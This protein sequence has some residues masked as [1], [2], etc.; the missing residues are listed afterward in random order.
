MSLWFANLACNDRDIVGQYKQHHV[1]N[2]YT[3]P[4]DRER[5]TVIRIDE[6]LQEQM[7]GA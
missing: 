3:S 6:Y 5:Q 1:K 4:R 2:A 7:S